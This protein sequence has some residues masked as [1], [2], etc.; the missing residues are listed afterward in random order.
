MAQRRS[1]RSGVEDRWR[2]ADGT[3]SA[4]DGQ[5][6]RWRAR[7]VD[8]R[9]VERE[10]LFARKV[11]AA[12][13]LDDVTTSIGVGDYVDPVRGAVTFAAFYRR[14]R[15][16][17]VWV[18][19][20]ADAVELAASS[21]TFGDVPLADLRPSHVEAWVKEMQT[22]GL[23]PSTIR[24]RYN[25]VRSVLRAAVRDRLLAR[26]VAEGLTLPRPRKAEARMQIPLPR[27]VGQLIDEA[28]GD[29]G[30]FVAVSAFGGL[31][32]GEVAGLRLS[33]VDFLGREIHVRRQVQRIGGGDVEVRGPK[34]GS[35]RTVYAPA[36]LME[37]LAEHVRLNCPGDDPDRWLWTA[38]NGGPWHHDIVGPR[39]RRLRER[40]G[41]DYHLHDLRHFYASGLIAAGCDVVTVQ[42]ALGH[43]SASITL[44]TYSHLWPTAEDRTR[45]AAEAMFAEAS[46]ETPAGALRATDSATGSDLRV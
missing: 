25:N 17:Q 44:S 40:V 36:P 5:G 6:K 21:V 45:K 22:R 13:F 26:D 30:A 39:W 9:G 33:D 28:D 41:V 14:W 15:E 23:A 27:E 11:D 32:L 34:Y 19:G 46:S 12:R 7:Y 2:R 10:K 20:T 43:A 29:L 38:R 4:R 24:T 8:D 16:R 3:P 18:R 35:E 1:R 37:V 42:R 31:R